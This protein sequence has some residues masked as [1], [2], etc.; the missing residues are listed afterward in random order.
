[1]TRKEN[2]EKLPQSFYG[3]FKSSSSNKSNQTKQ[4]N[5][6]HCFVFPKMFNFR[7]C[8]QALF[9]SRSSQSQQSAA[10]VSWAGKLFSLLLQFFF[11]FPSSFFDL[12]RAGNERWKVLSSA[13]ELSWF[14][15]QWTACCKFKVQ[16]DSGRLIS[17]PQL[18]C[19]HV[20]SLPYQDRCSFIRQTPECHAA[21]HYFDYL[22]FIFC[23]IGE[24]GASLY[25]LAM[26]LLAV[27]CL[28]LFTILAATA[29]KL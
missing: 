12:L 25:I 10:K 4:S 28:Y 13:R 2:F 20:L 5:S 22:D 16:N 3:T 19:S 21:V 7:N 9:S 26:V 17:S 24:H 23:T 29:D 27:G 1:M 15:R 14:Q 8:F 11:A 18:P 6:T